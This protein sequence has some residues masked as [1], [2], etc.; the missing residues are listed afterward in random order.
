MESTR[1]G[2]SEAAARTGRGVTAGRGGGSRRADP[3][4]YVTRGRLGFLTV[5]D[6][7]RSATL[8][9]GPVRGPEHLELIHRA[10]FY[11][12]PVSAIAAFRTAVAYIAFYESASRFHRRTGLIR[13]YAAVLGISRVR[14]CDLPGLTWPARGA[15]DA[16][17]Y[18]FDLGPMQALPRPITNPDRLRIAFRFPDFERFRAAATLRDLGPRGPRDPKAGDR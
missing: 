9:V 5:A 17:Y 1:R 6:G 14:R 7:G 8:M 16:P 15:R 18:R 12:V 10:G 2:R 3:R 11:H 13:E 4:R